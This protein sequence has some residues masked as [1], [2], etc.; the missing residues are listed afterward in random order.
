[1]SNEKDLL[2]EATVSINYQPLRDFVIHQLSIVPEKFWTI[3]A[4]STGK[5]HPEQ[6]NGEGGLVRHI[7]A[8]LY[9][10]REFCIAYNVT[11]EEKDCII[12]AVILHDTGKAI[13]EPHDIVNATALR[14]KVKDEI[15]LKAIEGARWHMGCWATGSTHGGERGF[16]RFPQDFNIVEQ[17]VHVA[18]Y[19]ASR[20]RVNL[21]KLGI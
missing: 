14:W 1:M 4:S 5:H 20:K 13:A 2:H 11:D 16:K 9:F 12:A 6:S 17:V 10:A 3:P 21:T 18:D 19:A 15:I 7:L 8:T